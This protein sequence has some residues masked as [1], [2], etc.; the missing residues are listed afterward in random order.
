MADTSD[1]PTKSLSVFA[2]ETLVEQVTVK[3]TNDRKPIMPEFYL[4]GEAAVEVLTGARVRSGK[5]MFGAHQIVCYSVNADVPGADQYEIYEA[6]KHYAVRPPDAAKGLWDFQGITD[7]KDPAN[8]IFLFRQ[9]GHD[10]REE[11]PTPVKITLVGGYLKS[12]HHL[13]S[14]V[15]IDPQLYS[16]EPSHLNFKVYSP[17]LILIQ[18][19]YRLPVD[20]TIV[21]A[22]RQ[23]HVILLLLEKGFKPALDNEKGTGNETLAQFSA[24]KCLQILHM[25]RPEVH[26]RSRKNAIK[27]SQSFA[28]VCAGVY[29]YREQRNLE[30]TLNTLDMKD[31]LGV[32]TNLFGAYAFA[33]EKQSR[34]QA[35]AQAYH[36]RPSTSYP[37]APPA[38]GHSYGYAPHPQDPHYVHARPRPHPAA[39]PGYGMN[40]SPRTW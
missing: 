5:S 33:A 10:R 15:H 31:L 4:R 21:N 20:K 14:S 3:G 34:E 24:G 35:R 19:L 29:K 17:T 26:E 23:I 2:T 36:S 7:T 11:P 32:L 40:Y 22:E 1:G 30:G 12:L 27:L 39:P 28:P 13:I 8:S 38:F 9:P 37:Q 25:L 18:L 16:F 6:L